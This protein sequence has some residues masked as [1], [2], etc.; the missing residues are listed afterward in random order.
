MPDLLNSDLP[1][2]DLLNSE[3]LM[4]NE[5]MLDL[6]PSMLGQLISGHSKVDL[7]I[8]VQLVSNQ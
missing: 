8:S 1:K 2:R 3:Q 7:L 5:E 4:L 6:F